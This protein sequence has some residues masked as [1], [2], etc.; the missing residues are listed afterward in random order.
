M[1]WKNIGYI[2]LLLKCSKIREKRIP[3][4]Y[5]DHLL[6][7]HTRAP[8]AERLVISRQDVETI[9]EHTANTNISEMFF[10]EL[11]NICM[12]HPEILQDKQVLLKFLNDC[13]I[14]YERCSIEPGTPV[15]VIAVQSFSERL[16][17]ATLNAFHLSG[18]K[19]S[20]V[21]GVRSIIDMLRGVLSPH[22]T[23]IYPFPNNVDIRPVFVKD[24]VLTFGVMFYPMIRFHG[25][26]ILATNCV[27]CYY[28]VIDP[29]YK[30]QKEK[31]KTLLRDQGI[32]P[33][34]PDH[35]LIV[36][37]KKKPAMS[38]Y[39]LKSILTMLVSGLV[40]G[41]DWEFKDNILTLHD[42]SK[43]F[44]VIDFDYMVKHIGD[45]LLETNFFTKV[46][47]NNLR[48]IY[49]NLGIEAVRT[50]LVE[51]IPAVLEKEGIHISFSHV[52]LIIDNMTYMGHIAPYTRS[53]VDVNQSVLLRASFETTTNTL[54][55]AAASALS[56]D[57]KC[58][59]SSIIFGKPSQIGTMYNLKII[60][61]D[62]NV[63]EEEEEIAYAPVEIPQTQEEVEDD[64]GDHF[65]FYA[66]DH[67]SDGEDESPK[68][69]RVEDSPE[70]D[71]ELEY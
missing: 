29:M 71:I 59:T 57:I 67:D 33:F 31:L 53:G 37:S 16:T 10:Y 32:E 61:K 68:R 30:A 43:G 50:Y 38:L 23:T 2:D 62:R 15:G 35:N 8:T 28:F 54:S 39:K 41:S 52:E 5:V 21:T 19:D 25:K 36:L 64:V 11:I 34:E 22:S 20:P 58:P 12:K 63:V 24:M 4:L 17:Q 48:F 60:E 69:Q 27:Y 44:G 47:S 65:H 3:N 66:S 40:W 45:V 70:Y 49:K 18:T 46:R 14:H 7:R 13:L 9:K 51:T 6:K 55:S 26:R 1:S 42:E 56:D